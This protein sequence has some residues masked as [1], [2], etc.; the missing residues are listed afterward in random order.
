MSWIF[1]GVLCFILHAFKNT[2]LREEVR[3]LL[4]TS[5]KS[6]AH[7][8]TSKSPRQSEG[9]WRSSL[10]HDFLEQS[11]RFFPFLGEAGKGGN[12]AS[13]DDVVFPTG[14]WGFFLSFCHLDSELCSRKWWG[15]PSF[16]LLII[17]VTTIM[18]FIELGAL[19][20]SLYKHHLTLEI[21]KKER[22]RERERR[23]RKAK[24]GNGDLWWFAQGKQGCP[25]P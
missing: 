17:K 6:N 23:E 5:K 14:N 13:W 16:K 10:C 21:E 24:Q 12:R 22:E 1:F 9:T 19:S 18:C 11:L 8:H 2:S 25:F 3:R 7:M 15:P 20:N 4:L